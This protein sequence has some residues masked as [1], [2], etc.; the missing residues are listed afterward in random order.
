MKL[1][2]FIINHFCCTKSV[3]SLAHPYI[4]LGIIFSLMDIFTMCFYI[5]RRN[6]TIIREA[7][8]RD[9]KTREGVFSV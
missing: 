7:N 5:T 6:L 9:I 1:I 3:S 4:A 2:K 8:K